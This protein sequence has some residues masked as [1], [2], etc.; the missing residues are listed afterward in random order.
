MVEVKNYLSYDGL[1]LY[2]ELIKKYIASADEAVLNQI[3]GDLE[4]D[5]DPKTIA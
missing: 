4:S 2:D 3:L 5:A 1:K